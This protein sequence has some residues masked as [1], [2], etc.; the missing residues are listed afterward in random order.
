MC[1]AT[2]TAVLWAGNQ[3]LQLSYTVL[4][5]AVLHLQRLCFCFDASRGWSDNELAEHRMAA[6]YRRRL[7]SATLQLLDL[8]PTRYSSLPMQPLV[9]STSSSQ[10]AS[11]GLTVWQ[12]ACE[13]LHKVADWAADRLGQ[14]GVSVTEASLVVEGECDQRQAAWQ[15]T[16]VKAATGP[17]ACWH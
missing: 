5:Q 14:C 2:A 15:Q 9:C 1:R 7:A 3:G 4:D 16:V 13:V 11:Q 6:I 8:A 12:V 17:I 10:M